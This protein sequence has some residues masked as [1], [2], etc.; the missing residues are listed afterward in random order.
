MQTIESKQNGIDTT[1]LRASMKA[2]AQK[3]GE[4]KVRFHVC[5]EWS[6]GT[7]STTRVEDWQIGDKT[8]GRSFTILADEPPELLGNSI[9]P[10]PQ[11]LLMAGLNACLTVGY[12]TGCSMRGIEV[13]SL[14]IETEGDLD[15]R[16]FLG[17]D[18]NVKPGYDELR[19]TVRIRS[20]GTKE[21]IQQ[22]HD[23]VMATSPNFFNLAN[24]IRLKPTLVV[25]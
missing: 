7:Q 8:Q 22:I 14:E 21:Q 5:T 1:A 15:L 25:E 6:G 16:G 20:S 17:L 18:P 3:P 19:Y 12:V 13:D 11:E 23:T 2:I 24:P 10:N 9:A 4:G